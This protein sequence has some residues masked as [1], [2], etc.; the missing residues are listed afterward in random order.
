MMGVDP[1]LSGWA[2]CD[3]KSPCK[4]EAESKAD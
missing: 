3:A 4:M 2:Q 1:V